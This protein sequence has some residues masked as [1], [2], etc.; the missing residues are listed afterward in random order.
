MVFDEN[1]LVG[2][3]QIKTG[4]EKFDLVEGALVLTAVAPDSQV[5]GYGIVL[6]PKGVGLS[7]QN[8]SETEDISDTGQ[9]RIF[10]GQ[11][12]KLDAN[13]LQNH[14]YYRVAESVE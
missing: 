6:I 14:I 5:G 8:L 11:Q 3:F 13:L 1:G 12:F 10:A 4:E 2:E 9:D 7:S